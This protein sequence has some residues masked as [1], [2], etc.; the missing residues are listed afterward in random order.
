MPTNYEIRCRTLFPNRKLCDNIHKLWGGSL[1]NNIPPSS[2][3]T[4]DWCAGVN[5]LITVK[6]C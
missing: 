3:R 1:L 4:L 5:S 6:T 2:T